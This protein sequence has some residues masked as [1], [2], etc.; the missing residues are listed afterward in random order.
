MAETAQS[1]YGDDVARHRAAVPQRVECREA[2]AHQRGRLNGRQVL[3]HE[4]NCTGGG[5]QELPI[6]AV[7][8]DAGDLTAHAGEELS[9]ATVIAI[10][11]IAA[12]PADSHLLARLPSCDTG[13]ERIDH[14]GHFMAGNPGVLKSWENPLFR[15]RIA[16]AD[17]ASLHLTPHQPGDW[18]RDG[19]FHDLEGAFGA[20]DLSDPHHGHVSSL[21]IQTSRA[22]TGVMEGAALSRTLERRDLCHRPLSRLLTAVIL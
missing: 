19:T 6:A 16:V 17:A 10:P 18:L 5:D 2:C 11:A 1:E 9:T 22:N 13:A 12:I 3:W 8:R 15:D 20:G 21:R 4:R 14:P 7:I